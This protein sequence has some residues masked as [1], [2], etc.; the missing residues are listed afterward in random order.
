MESKTNKEEEDKLNDIF[1]YKTNFSLVK[2]G[3]SKKNVFLSL[4]N[5]KACQCR[6]NKSHLNMITINFPSRN[7]RNKTN[8]SLYASKT[9]KTDNNERIIRKYKILRLGKKFGNSPQKNNNIIDF[10]GFTFLVEKSSSNFDENNKRNN[11]T[12]FNTLYKEKRNK[13][14]D[15]LKNIKQKDNIS[16]KA[17]LKTQVI[18]FPKKSNSKYYLAPLYQNKKTNKL[19]EETS[20]KRI[21][22]GYLMTKNFRKN[23]SQCL[24]KDDNK[25]RGELNPN[26]KLG[27]KYFP[28]DK[29]K[30]LKER[31]EFYSKLEKIYDEDRERKLRKKFTSLRNCHEVLDYY[32]KH[33]ILNCRKLIERTLYDAKKAKKE[34]CKFFEQYKKVFD[35]YDDWNDPKNADN[36]YN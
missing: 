14:N 17:N 27:N 24:L 35:V 36:L 22:V 29:L 34:V 5:D 19:E 10:K 2:N 8:D 9:I 6:N 18:N 12:N 26:F 21:N 33:R 30:D 16:K 7:K 20:M 31:N 25:Y 1:N 32:R 23:I 28:G 11:L 13:S 15:I 4:Q 3:T